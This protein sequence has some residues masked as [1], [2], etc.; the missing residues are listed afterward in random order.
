MPQQGGGGAEQPALQAVVSSGRQDRTR[1]ILAWACPHDSFVWDC[2]WGVRSQH[3][4]LQP[5]SAGVQRHRT[6]D[7]VGRRQLDHPQPSL[8][9]LG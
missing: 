3:L 4:C 7:S 9:L 5:N 2:S 1:Q 8:R 6:T